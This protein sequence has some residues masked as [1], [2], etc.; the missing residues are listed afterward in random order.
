MTTAQ[1]RPIWPVQSPIA[2]LT[3][4]TR[5]SRRRVNWHSAAPDFEVEVRTR[6]GT[7]ASYCSYHLAHHHDVVGADVDCCKVPVNLLFASTNRQFHVVAITRR[8]AKGVDLG[9]SNF[10]E[11]TAGC[12]D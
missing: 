11:A 9:S 4:G 12:L 1:R 6:G 8:Y 3:N 7:D 10:D 5:K 2:R